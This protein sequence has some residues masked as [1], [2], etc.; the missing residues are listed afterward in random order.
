MNQ[1]ICLKL[2]AAKCAF[3]R[4]GWFLYLLPYWKYLLSIR[5]GQK[6]RC[7]LTYLRNDWISEEEGVRT[8][9]IFLFKRAL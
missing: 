7:F 4:R 5:K 8:K 1:K 3:L 2:N 9:N 6:E